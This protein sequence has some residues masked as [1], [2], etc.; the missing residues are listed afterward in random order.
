MF[1]RMS[2]I[3]FTRGLH[4]GGDLPT[5]R[6][7]GLGRSPP[8]LEKQAIKLLECFLVQY[9]FWNLCFRFSSWIIC[10]MG[11]ISVG[12]KTKCSITSHLNL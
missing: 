5:S 4:Q 9:R 10:V 7:G 11:L 6:E 2:V 1:L 12:I 8:E 3:L